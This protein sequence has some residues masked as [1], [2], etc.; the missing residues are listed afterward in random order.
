MFSR[1]SHVLRPEYIERIR[2]MD[3]FL[4]PQF[5]MLTG[6]PV[7]IDTYIANFKYILP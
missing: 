7:N 4:T 3:T 5:T 1:Q 6:S 2:C